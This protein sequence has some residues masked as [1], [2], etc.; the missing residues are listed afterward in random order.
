MKRVIYL[1][2]ILIALLAGCKKTKPLA[3]EADSIELSVQ[4]LN[5]ESVLESQNQTWHVTNKRVCIIFGYDFNSPE[6]VEKF[7]PPSASDPSSFIPGVRMLTLI[8]SSMT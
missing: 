3:V 8:G 4:P 2:I 5:N 6:A 7:T 1:V